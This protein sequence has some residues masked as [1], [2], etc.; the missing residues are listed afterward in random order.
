MSGR[1]VD[2]P[3]TATRLGIIR[4]GRVGLTEALGIVRSVSC[5]PCVHPRRHGEVGVGTGTVRRAVD[6]AETKGR[7]RRM[8]GLVSADRVHHRRK[9]AGSVRDRAWPTST[10]QAADV[11]EP[12]LTSE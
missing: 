5:D 7:G 11:A 10:G 1:E 12:E 8:P 9:A 4:H 6:K 3:D 2:L